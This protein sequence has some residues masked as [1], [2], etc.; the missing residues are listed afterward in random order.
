[1]LLGCTPCGGDAAADAMRLIKTQ[2]RVQVEDAK[3]AKLD[4]SSQAQVR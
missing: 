4:E 3:L 1:M 2:G